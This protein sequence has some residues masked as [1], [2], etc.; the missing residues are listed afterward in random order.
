MIALSVNNS[1]VPA[2]RSLL[3]R[4]TFAYGAKKG[5]KIE[6]NAFQQA[7]FDKLKK[8]SAPGKHFL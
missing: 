8:T 5:A 6:E 2:K 7:S 1:D 3:F 4:N